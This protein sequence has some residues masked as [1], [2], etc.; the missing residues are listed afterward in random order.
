MVGVTV[1][2][3]IAG[4]IAATVFA[5]IPWS[6]DRASQQSL[7]P[8]STAQG[9]NKAQNGV[10]ETGAALKSRSLI[11]VF[12]AVEVDTKPTSDGGWAAA[13][14]SAT[15][16]IYL[17]TNLDP[18]PQDMTGQKVTR[19][20]PLAAPVLN[21]PSVSSTGGSFAAG[22]YYFVVTAISNAETTRSNEVSVTT[23]GSTSSVT[24]SFAAV[25]GAINYRL[26]RSTSPGTETSLF[27]WG[28]TTTITDDGSG[29]GGGSV[30]PSTNN[31]TWTETVVVDS[32]ASALSTR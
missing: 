15:G 24:I 20:S 19:T 30:P 3:A 16:K 25:P 17:S 10:Y 9:V 14:M 18:K 27:Q 1:I 11:S 26:Y 31:A 8:M 7:E 5:V 13:S 12:D 32:V 29:A 23:T 2:G 22:T 28:G 6:Q 4:T 21:T